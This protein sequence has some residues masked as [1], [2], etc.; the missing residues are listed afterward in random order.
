[1]SRQ[2]IC[3]SCHVQNIIAEENEISIEY[4]IQRKRAWNGLLNITYSEQN[5]TVWKLRF[6]TLS[7]GTGELFEFL[8]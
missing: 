7:L 6:S 2:H 5:K 1:M 8:F 3:L 4:E